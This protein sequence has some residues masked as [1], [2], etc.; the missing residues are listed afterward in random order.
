MK[1][2]F[3]WLTRAWVLA[4]FGALALALIVWFDGPLI[5]FNGN[6]PLESVS[7]RITLIAI[8]FVLWAGFFVGK[9]LI[10]RIASLKLMQSVAAQPAAADP[11]LAS[12]SPA[13]SAGDTRS[14]AEV[15]ALNQRFQE[16]LAILRQARGGRRFGGQYLYQTP[17]YMFVGAPG[18]GK[19]TA[20][21]HSGLKF[22]LA[23]K[24]GKE[25]IRGIG[26]TRNCDWWFT[27]EA[28][29]LDTAGRY[30]TQD[31]DSEADKAA[32][33][34]FLQLLKKYRRRRPI[35]GVIVAVSVAD[36]LR[37]SEA[38][39]KTQAQAIRERIKELH[40]RLG[41]RFPI[42]VLVTKCDLMAGFVEFF[43]DLGREERA[44][45]WGMTFPVADA[46]NIDQLLATFPAE[47]D[48]LEARLQARVLERLQ[49]ERDV[50]RRALIY[51]FPQ[52]L[53]SLRDL[54]GGF[55]GDVFQSSRYEENAL[56]RG[57][58]FTS[59][60]Q[61]GSPIDRVMGALAASF[62]IDRQV[63][64]ANTAS[65]RSYFITRLLRD[66]LFQE[67]GLA[68]ADLRVERRRAWLQ[69]GAWV[70]AAVLIVLMSAGLVT[71]YVRNRS[72][73]R[74]VASQVDAIDAQARNLVPNA[75]VLSVLP[76]LDAARDIPGGY[77]DRNGGAPF[78]MTLGLYQGDKL[79]SAAQT[80]YQRLLRQTLLPRVVGR[81]KEQLRRGEANN[82]QYLYETLRVYLMLGDPN[83][84][85]A[86]SVGAWADYDWDRNLA[87][88]VTDD[89]RK[90]L[91]AHMTALLDHL[92]DDGPVTLD[93]DLVASTRQALARIPLQ[94]RVYASLLRNLQHTSSPEVSLASAAGRDAAIVFV[95]KS[96]EPMTRGVPGLFTRDGYRQFLARRD[97]AVADVVKDN[98]IL[99]KDEAVTDPAAVEQLNA[100]VLELYYDDYI[101]RW[102]AFLSDVGIVPF[103]DLDQ[104]AC[105]VNVLAQPTSP[106]KKFLSVAA[107][108]TT[109][110]DVKQTTLIDT[111]KGKLDSV[112]KKLESALAS[113]D[114]A[115]PAPAATLQNPVDLHF[116]SLHQLAA[117]GAGGASPLDSQLASLNEVFVYLDAANTAKRQ[118]APAPASDALMKLKQGAEGKPAPLA[119]MLAGVADAGSS[120]TLGSERGR[121]SSL[122]VANVASFCHQA[123]DGRYPLVRSASNAVTQ[124]DFGRVFAPGG[125]IDDFFQHNLMPYVDMSKTRWSWRPFGN[126]SLGIPEDVLTQFQRAAQIRDAFFSGGGKM[127][128]ARFELK[129]VTMDAAVTQF[130]LDIDGQTLTYGHGPTRSTAFQWPNGKV[131][132]SVR[133]DYAPP[134]AGGSSGY[135]TDGPWAWFRMI[136][137]G[138]LEPTAQRDRYNL[139]LD[140]DGR[141]VTLELRASS[142]VNPFNLDALNKFTCPAKL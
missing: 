61:E 79:G 3:S 10:G 42:Y 45:V 64:V 41:I 113:S 37:Q 124:D 86:E 27:D 78:L 136:D 67:S 73:V 47:F 53:A 29:L 8:I 94:Q 92:Q 25:A 141:K 70:L 43:D 134:G 59:G 7:S 39:R 1:R 55:L 119:A 83:H 105:V 87:G 2:L 23:D 123:I 30:T 131:S 75:G 49:Q 34:G 132:S 6:A 102:D 69:R 120:L 4:L 81:L 68:G 71:S 114:D 109:L 129:P 44:S 13:P 50:R 101:R 99:G 26:G 106:L 19:T 126:V 60:T 89:Q 93:A 16:A 128:S 98:W 57:V 24:L 48:A 38:D 15:S 32:W 17:W 77:A 121:L 122:W 111:A 118:G 91:S 12:A 137:K 110:G 112:K 33:T 80:L 117:A 63:L 72:Y 5:A 95:R 51:G 103:H 135:S 85:D 115:A 74:E 36:L 65:G 139:T 62:G 9:W 35:N 84:F 52:Q 18:A 22:P 56:L 11:A 127:A 133:V 138:V 142:V 130:T 58:Y 66:V 108:E 28:V 54:L 40:E 14:A 96:G 31:S 20:L 76:L 140:L 104:A 107:K 97:L 90:D 116:D 125:L 21:V 88:H 100:Q 46:A 82:P